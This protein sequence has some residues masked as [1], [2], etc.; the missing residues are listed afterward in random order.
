[1]WEW[2]GVVP[3]SAG[4]WPLWMVAGNWTSMPS[5]DVPLNGVAEPEASALVLL[6]VNN[7]APL[8]AGRLQPQ[9]GMTWH[10]GPSILHWVMSVSGARLTDMSVD[11]VHSQYTPC[12]H[13]R[14]C[15]GQ[16]MAVAVSNY[17][18]ILHLPREPLP[19][20][21]LDTTLVVPASKLA[22]FNLKVEQVLGRMKSTPL[23]WK[24]L[25]WPARWW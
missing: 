4:E 25:V 21:T 14:T 3:Y 15:S 16:L 24:R 6:T 1:M 20:P 8:D 2:L 10:G 7:W 13:L 5:Q 19:D 22:P 11:I 23:M 12:W 9:P 18:A 17:A